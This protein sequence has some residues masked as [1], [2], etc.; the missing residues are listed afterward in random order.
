MLDQLVLCDLVLGCADPYFARA[1]LGAGYAHNWLTGAATIP[2]DRMQFD[3]EKTAF[4]FAD[5]DNRQSVADCS[6]NKCVGFAD[7]GRAYFTVPRR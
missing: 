5:D 7:Q 2:H 3:I 4:G 6:C 1:A